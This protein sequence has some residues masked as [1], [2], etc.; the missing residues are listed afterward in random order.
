M[1]A[2]ICYTGMKYIPKKLSTRL[3]DLAAEI[4]DF[5]KRGREK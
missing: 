1:G 5:N 4:R 3:F 2:T